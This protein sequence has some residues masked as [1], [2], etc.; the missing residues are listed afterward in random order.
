MKAHLDA[1]HLATGRADRFSNDASAFRALV[2]ADAELARRAEVLVSVPGVGPVTAAGLLTEMPELGEL[3]DQSAAS[4]AGLA[5]ATRESGTWK[6][7][8]FIRGA[9]ARAR[10]LLYMPALSAIR[11]NP[12]FKRKYCELHGRGSRRRCRGLGGVSAP[13]FK[14]R[15]EPGRKAAYG[16]GQLPLAAS[17]PVTRRGGT[18]WSSRATPPA[19][20]RL[21][22]ATRPAFP[23]PLRKG[24][25]RTRPIIRK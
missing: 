20:E 15:T 21:D 13:P 9:R 6:G 16:L 3:D 18:Q 17:R 22:T 24:A 10:R 23:T 4:L 2:A 7:R 1:H 11:H 5:P 12:D 25:G 8:G 14:S 19:V